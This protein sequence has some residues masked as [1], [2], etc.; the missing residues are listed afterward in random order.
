MI[1]STAFFI[2][3][4]LITLVFGLICSVL[5]LIPGRKPLAYGIQLYGSAQRVALF[6]IA[7]ISIDVRGRDRL[8]LQ[9]TVIA[10]KHRLEPGTHPTASAAPV[11][12]CSTGTC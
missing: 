9:P 6:F 4:W 10:A 5:A 1:R 12:P 8:P 3:Y 7:G 2:A 11:A